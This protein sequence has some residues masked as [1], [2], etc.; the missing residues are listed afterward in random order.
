MGITGF[1]GYSPRVKGLPIE[2]YQKIVPGLKVDYRNPD[3]LRFTDKGNNLRKV[4]EL[5]EEWVTA[6]HKRVETGTFDYPAICPVVIAD[7]DDN[8]AGQYISLNNVVLDGNSRVAAA[9]LHT[10]RMPVILIE[11]PEDLANVRKL[12]KTKK[13]FWYHGGSG[14]KKGFRE[15][16]ASAQEAEESVNLS[17]QNFLD[18]LVRRKYDLWEMR[19]GTGLY[20]NP[21]IFGDSSLLYCIGR[22]TFQEQLG[23]AR[24][25]LNKYVLEAAEEKDWEYEGYTE[26][27]VVE[28]RAANRRNL[29]VE[30]NRY[31][32]RDRISQLIRNSA[33]T[34]VNYAALTEGVIDFLT[35]GVTDSEGSHRRL[36]DA[37]NALVKICR[38]EENPKVSIL[39]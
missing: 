18:D 2:E 4:M 25:T 19:E 38:N 34:G 17:G 24:S 3:D 10:S 29:P 16:M 33:L 28:Q 31:G 22:V 32:L 13:F 5:S 23:E 1:G 7:V 30:I 15:L 37:V 12:H 39:N 14:G 6:I 8:F 27:E 26:D 21:N 20:F 11:T 35:C 36:D 9:S